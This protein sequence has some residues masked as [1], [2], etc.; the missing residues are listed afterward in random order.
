MP[1]QFRAIIGQEFSGVIAYQS[2]KNKCIEACSVSKIYDLH[3]MISEL[4]PYNSI[5]DAFETIIFGGSFQ[6]GFDEEGRITLPQELMDCAGLKTQSELCF[7][8][9]GDVFEIWDLEE[10]KKYSHIAKDV[11]MANKEILGAKIQ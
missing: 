6:L 4:E 1:A 3:K 9:K 2:I 11:A 8:G 5:R 10:F 7:I